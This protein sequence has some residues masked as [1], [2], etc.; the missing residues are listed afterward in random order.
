MVPRTMTFIFRRKAEK[1]IT[2]KSISALIV[3]RRD[4]ESTR[5]TLRASSEVRTSHQEMMDWYNLMS[6]SIWN[7]AYSLLKTKEEV[8]LWSE[9][10]LLSWLKRYCPILKKW[11]R[12][13]FPDKPLL[14]IS[15]NRTTSSR[16]CVKVVSPERIKIIK[17][18]ISKVA[19]ATFQILMATLPK[20]L[21]SLVLPVSY[22]RSRLM[23][24]KES[25]G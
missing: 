14:S 11:R 21:L 9:K 8:A 25:V 15:H 13:C 23:T 17:R 5:A 3:I 16:P 1:W 7:R 10:F 2:P 24:P 20:L 18:R 12:I 4:M 22:K 6:T 19:A